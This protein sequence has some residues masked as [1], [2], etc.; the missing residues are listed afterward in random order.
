M[1]LF[2]KLN[3]FKKRTAIILDGKYIITYSKLLKDSKI[4]TNKIKKR[5]LI[6][7][8]GGNNYETISS[9]IGL[10]NIKSVILMLD[11]NISQSFLVDII[12]NYKPNFI[13]SPKQR[14]I[15]KSYSLFYDFK[16]YKIFK[17]NINNVIKLNKDLAVLLTTSGTT[18]SK[19]FVKQS[20]KNYEDNSKKIINSLGINK[21]SSVITTLPISYTY[22]LS[23]IN[24]HLISGST[25]ILNE[26]NI[27][28]Q[29]FWEIYNKF[30]PRYFY[31]VPFV[32]E[33]INRIGLSKLLNNKLNVVAN[34]GG[35]INKDLF[36][37]IAR[38]SKSKMI[39]FYNMYGQTEATS[40]MSILNFRHS[41]HRP[42]S[43]GKP[44]RGGKFYLLSDKNKLINKANVLGN[45]YYKGKNVSLG[46][47]NSFKDLY[48]KDKN[49]NIINTGDIAKFDNKGFFYIVG[50]KKRF[51]KLFGN[52]ISLDE[53]E[54]LVL[55]I[56]FKI[57]CLIS[58]DKLTI[59]YISDQTDVNMIKKK[60][61]NHFKINPKYIVF[62]H[63]SEI[64]NQEKSL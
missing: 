52:R 60:L 64:N 59:K 29:K 21:N 63:Q 54:K 41:L 19:K 44:L 50:R 27:L 9:Y 43:I 56:G 11:K 31:G 33:M 48:K 30:K 35:A 8:L 55:E 22:G 39:K 18:G 34:A 42:T 16:N 2:G 49:K 12:K 3:E 62:R 25:L 36:I 45:L 14:E 10:I 51:I 17:Q 38:W 53:I 40:R 58:D 24:T 20:Y 1:S 47:S 37:K 6:L 13:F 5:S 26:S 4:V 7:I 46:Y 57:K 32:F 15:P 28:N 61:S 23:I